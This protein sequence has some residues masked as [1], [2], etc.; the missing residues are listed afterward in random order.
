MGGGGGMQWRI[1]NSH[2]GSP[3]FKDYNEEIFQNEGNRVSE[4][5]FPNTEFC[6]NALFLKKCSAVEEFP[7]APS[8]ETTWIHHWGGMECL[9][10]GKRVSLVG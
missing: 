5:G 2:W 9:R 1:Q 8:P 10:I 6:Q 4:K 7:K 3:P